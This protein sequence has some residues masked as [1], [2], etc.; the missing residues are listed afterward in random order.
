VGPKQGGLMRESEKQL[1]QSYQR[2]IQKFDEIDYNLDK[3]EKLIW[4]LYIF[5]PLVAIAGVLI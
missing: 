3:T 4:G 5:V 2:V 1:E